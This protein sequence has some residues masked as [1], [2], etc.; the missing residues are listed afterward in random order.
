MH[1]GEERVKEAKVQTLKGWS[2]KNPTKILKDMKD[3]PPSRTYDFQK[4]G[5]LSEFEAIH[6]KDGK[7]IDDFTMKLTRSS[8]TSIH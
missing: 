4:F 2:S 5:F 8:V 7:S 6:M 1:V 3:L